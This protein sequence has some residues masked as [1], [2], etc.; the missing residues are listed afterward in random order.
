[1]A[2]KISNQ[3]LGQVMTDRQQLQYGDHYGNPDQLFQKDGSD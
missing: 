3:S 2:S 1:M